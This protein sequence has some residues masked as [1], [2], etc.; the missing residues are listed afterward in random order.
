M[1]P[2]SV[3]GLLVVVLPL[4]FALVF[5]PCG[6][7]VSVL[8]VGLGGCCGCVSLAFCARVVFSSGLVF[9]ESSHLRVSF[10]RSVGSLTSKLAWNMVYSTA[11]ENSSNLSETT[12][13]F[14]F[15]IA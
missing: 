8:L 9:S 13:Y 14:R 15:Y 4:G 12:I 10:V 2:G 7:F 3:V 1:S 5:L 6:S 11:Y